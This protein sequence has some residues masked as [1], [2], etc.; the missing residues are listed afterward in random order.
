MRKMLLTFIFHSRLDLEL[1]FLL[2][3]YGRCHI[4][5]AAKDVFVVTTDSRPV[6]FFCFS[7]CRFSRRH[8]VPIVTVQPVA[9]YV[10]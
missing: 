9:T 1:L 7:G 2:W 10:L 6:F 5:F 3:S 4:H 8:A